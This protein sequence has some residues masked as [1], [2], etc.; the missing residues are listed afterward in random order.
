MVYD[1]AYI[2][3]RKV[4]RASIRV[5]DFAMAS[6]ADS[7]PHLQPSTDNASVHRLTVH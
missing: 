6:D 5:T 4:R 3:S 7:D 2:R 1:I